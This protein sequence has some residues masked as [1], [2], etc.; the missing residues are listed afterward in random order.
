MTR[1]FSPNTHRPDHCHRG[2]SIAA[3]L[4]AIIAAPTIA[5]AD[6]TPRLPPPNAIAPWMTEGAIRATFAGKTIQGH[7]ANGTAFT[8]EYRADG[9]IDYREH[10]KTQAGH[11]SLQGNAFCTIYHRWATGGCYRVR[12]VSDNCYEFFFVA[13]TEFEAANRMTTRPSLTA[14]AAVA[15]RTATCEERPAV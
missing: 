5:L 2:P 12:Q 7:Y 6:R 11:W 4:A 9:A 15:D 13:R 8:E 1:L 10:D 14:R 3:G